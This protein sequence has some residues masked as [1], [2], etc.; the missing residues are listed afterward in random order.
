MQQNNFFPSATEDN[1][2]RLMEGLTTTILTGLND[3]KMMMVLSTILP[4]HT[5]PKHNHPHEQIGFVHSGKGIFIIGDEERVLVKGDFFS[6]PSNVP[7]SVVCNGDEPFLIVDIFCPVR[8]DFILKL[9]EQQ[10]S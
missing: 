4:G 6:I 3:E 10:R 8:E 5:V 1:Q 2:V 7:H 9:K